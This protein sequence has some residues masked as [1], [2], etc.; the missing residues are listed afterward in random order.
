MNV[1]E[2]AHRVHAQDFRIEVPGDPMPW[3]RASAKVMP[4]RGGREDLRRSGYVFRP[5][6]KFFTP[7]K[8]RARMDAIAATWR[9]AGFPMI[10]AGVPL[11]VVCRFV[12]A[13]PAGHYG[14][15]RNAT[16]VKPRHLGARP[17]KG[18]NKNAEGRRTGGDEDNLSKLA[19]DALSGVAYADDGQIARSIVEKLFVDQAG[20]DEPISIIEVRALLADAPALEVAA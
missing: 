17:G 5:W 20:V 9:E 15:G 11:E 4:S 2:L 19:K 6:I 13:R 3:P 14:T 8:A 18:G 1:D 12:F 10:P 16:T 7:T